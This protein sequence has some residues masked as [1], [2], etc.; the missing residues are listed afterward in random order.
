MGAADDDCTVYVGNLSFATD[1]KT[2]VREL[3]REAEALPVA[4]GLNI[5]DTVLE[6]AEERDADAQSSRRV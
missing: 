6:I 4:G 3:G 5:A 2:L 1:E